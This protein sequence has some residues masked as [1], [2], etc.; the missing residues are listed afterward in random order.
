MPRIAGS[1]TPKYRKHKASGQ[2]V[3]T[4]AGRD[5]YLGP[6]R[7]KASKIEYDR[8]IG[9]WL[10]AGR[11]S[12][13]L[14]TADDLT[15]TELLLRYWRFAQQHYR[16]DGEPTGEVNNIRAAAKPLK[17]L[18]G[19]TRAAEFSPLSLKALRQHMI[20]V[21]LCRTL[22]NQRIGIIRRIFK[23]GV[24]EAL[25]P[26]AVLQA[27]QAVDGLRRGRSEARETKPIGPVDDATVDATL[28][29]LPV[30][31]ADMVRF[32]RLVGCRPAEVCS[33]RPCDVDTSGDVWVFRP[34]SHK[35]EHHGRERRI[36]IG[37][38]AQD[39]LRPY[40]L[41]DKETCCFTPADSEKKRRAAIHERRVTPMSCGN[42]PGTNVKRRPK[43]RLKDRYNKDSYANAIRRGCKKACP[44]PESLSDAEARDWDK[45]HC[46]A[47]NRLRHS[48]ATKLRASY[49]IDAA[50]TVLGHADPKV[51]LTYAERDYALAARIMREVG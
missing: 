9:E 32:Q 48:V 35:T 25:V 34:A 29:F 2:A 20:G 38:Q 26:P 44:A 6:W 33:L 42:R 51:T 19:H 11:P 27:L 45:A 17:A 24:S 12:T 3:V 37:P 39:V 5:H 50:Q 15:L 7:S 21:G 40:L 16:K 47:P 36:Y 43:R 49:G 14:V 4:I 13:G 31:V 18:Y 8:L 10:A 28:P 22:I 1:V 46:W 41:R 23:W 30:V